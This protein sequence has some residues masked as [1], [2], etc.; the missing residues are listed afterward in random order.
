[1]HARIITFSL[2]WVLILCLNSAPAQQITRFQKWLQPSFFRGFDVG[3]YCSKSPCVRTQQDLFDLKN[4]GAN[5]AQINVYG[6]S[7]RYPEYPYAENPVGRASITEMVNFCRTAGIYYTIANRVGPG[8]Y[9]VADGVPSHVSTIWRKDS[10][11]QVAMYGKMLKEIVSGFLNDTLFVGLNLT[12]EPTPLAEFYLSPPNLRQALIDSGIDLHKVYK[13]WIDSVRTVDQDLPLIIQSA[14]FSNP[15]YW[16]DPVLIRKQDDPRIVYDFHQYE[17]ID[18][19]HNPVMNA[20]TYPGTYWN[21]TLQTFALW[22]SAFYH[23]TVLAKVREFQQKHA[24]P[25]FMGEFGLLFPQNYGENYLQDMYEITTGYGWH[26]ALWAWRG[27]TSSSEFG[28]DY[29]KFDNATGRMTHYWQTVLSVFKT[30]VSFVARRE[31]VAP[32]TFAL[33]Q[34]Y[35]NPFNPSTTIHFDL[36]QRAHVVLKVYNL[37]GEELATLIDEQKERGQYG[38]EWTPEEVATGVCFYRLEAIASDNPHQRFVETRKML[39]VR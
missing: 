31:G 23:N 15:E 16:G 38:I 32:C 21:A 10:T 22:D 19:T 30:P 9:D 4:T 12:V 6:E 24:V 20:A 28:F 1:M 18:Y 13:A 26:F 34:N 7:F 35:P 8:R 33:L 2:G 11:F 25:I 29:E 3:Y 14:Q 36:P 17:P 39:F 27:D 5:L 37:L